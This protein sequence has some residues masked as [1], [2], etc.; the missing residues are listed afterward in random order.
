VP[1]EFLLKEKDEYGWPPCTNL[2]IS[3][4]FNIENISSLFTKRAILMYLTSL[5]MQTPAFAKF[6]KKII[7]CLFLLS[8]VFGQVSLETYLISA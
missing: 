5:E 6:E 2:F 4:A 8:T 1:T 3:A 7:V